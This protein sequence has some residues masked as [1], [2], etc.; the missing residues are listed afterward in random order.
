VALGHPEW[1]I[2]IGRAFH[3]YESVEGGDMARWLGVDFFVRDERPKIDVPSHPPVTSP[4]VAIVGDSFSEALLRVWGNAGRPVL[5]EVLPCKATIDMLLVI[6]PTIVVFAPTER[7]L[8][9]C[10]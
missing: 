4:T 6:Q 8:G 5:V 1:L 7:Y 9:T 2:D 10:E 3:G